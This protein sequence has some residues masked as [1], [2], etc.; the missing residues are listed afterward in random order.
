[1]NFAG[2]K[3]NVRGRQARRQL[4]DVPGRAC[5]R[6]WPPSP[7]SPLARLAHAARDRWRSGRDAASS[8]RRCV[9]APGSRE[10]SGTR[11]TGGTARR[12]HE[13]LQTARTPAAATPARLPRPAA[14]GMMAPWAT[15]RPRHRSRTGAPA[16]GIPAHVALELLNRAGTCLTGSMALDETLGHV[17]RLAVPAIADWCAVLL[18]EEDGSEREITSGHPDPEVEATLLAIRRRRRRVTGGSESLEVLRS[19]RSILATDV[20]GIAA[21]DV[22]EEELRG[23]GARSR[24]ARTC[25]CRCWPAGACW[26]LHAALDAARAPLHGRRPVLRRDAGRALRAGHRQR[27]AARR[28]RAARSPCSTRCSPRRRSA[29]PSS[30]SSERYVR[31]NAAL[32]AMNGRAVEEHLGPHGAGGARRRGRRRGRRP[33]DRRAQRRAGARAR[34][35]RRDRAWPRRTRLR[36][37]VSSFTPVHA[38]DGELLGVSVVVI[39]NTER[40]RLL[41]RQ[42]EALEAERAARARAD[43]LVA[44]GRHPRLVARLRGDAAQRGRTSPCPR[45][46]TGARSAC[47]TRTAASSRWPTPTP[48]RPCR[49]SAAS[50]EERFPLDPDAPSGPARVARTGVSAG[51]AR[52]RRRDARR[53]HIADPDQLA[54]VR[55]LGLAVGH[56][57]AARRARGARSARS[58]SPSPS[59]GAASATRTCSS[60]RSSR[61]A[62]AWRSTTPGSTRSAAASPTRCRRGC[63]PTRL[64]GI[65]GVR[66]AARYRAAGELNEVGGDFYDVFPRRDREWALLVGDV[67]GKG[68]EARGRHRA[69]PLHPARRRAASRGPPSEA[70]QRL[71]AAMRAEAGMSEFVTVALAYVAPGADGA[72][73]VRLALGGHPP[74]MSCAPTGGWRRSRQ[75]GAVLGVV[76]DPRC[77]TRRLALAPGDTMVLYTDGVTEAGPRAAPLGEARARAAALRPRRRGSRGAAGRRRGG[78]RR[79]AA[80]RAARR[81]RAAGR[82][83]R[84]PAPV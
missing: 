61:A 9:V 47:S 46:R 21:P 39:D 26:R 78:R 57:R 20:T 66:L 55:T 28:G 56:R 54:F 62:P 70:L 31:V 38:P 72:L 10:G 15:G 42:R 16:P 69:R 77:P 80:G 79:G 53:A 32:A 36:H 34:D 73:R 22:R 44:R 2:P 37:W 81:H 30:T 27:P 4:A 52:G 6:S 60:P 1:M 83:G 14:L 24:R 84:A 51:R 18:V 82:H 43:L 59:P 75:F 71:N 49:R 17:V 25:S 35:H 76:P 67:S 23:D 13:D 3:T 7:G 40:R 12:G 45:S 5:S 63:C 8:P 65:P 33:P 74:P 58:R 41:E 64:P 48:I 11:R 19:G 68:A 29:S 50:Y